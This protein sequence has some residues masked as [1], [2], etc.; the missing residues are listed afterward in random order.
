MPT[1]T[2]DAPPGANADSNPS[3]LDNPTCEDD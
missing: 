3:R 2:A 1:R